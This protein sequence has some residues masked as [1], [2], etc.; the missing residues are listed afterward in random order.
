MIM[1]GIFFEQEFPQGQQPPVF[2]GQQ[3]GPQQPGMP[4]E[5]IQQ[6]PE[7]KPGQVVPG[8]GHVDSQLGELPPGMPPPEM[9][10]EEIPAEES[11]EM[12]PLKKFY[13][14]QKLQDLK[15]RL[16][17][18]GITN[19]DLETV[20]K[21][22]ESFSYAVLLNLANALLKSVESDIK[23]YSKFLTQE[24]KRVAAAARKVKKESEQKARREQ[25][26][27]EEPEVGILTPNE[28]VPF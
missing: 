6:P 14:V 1:F 16:L 13:L 28:S 27:P 8:G 5:Q 11:P 26:K 22:G 18:N 9:N 17:Q 4:Q 20:L 21:F 10:P 12:E 24:A 7:V 25:S 23:S 19:D 2:Q 3:P 15:S